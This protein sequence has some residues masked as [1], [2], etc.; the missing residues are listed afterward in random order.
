MMSLYVV[1]LH[2]IL[3]GLLRSILSPHSKREAPLDS[4][5]GPVVFSSEAR[6]C[7]SQFNPFTECN[8]NN[9]N[10]FDQVGSLLLFIF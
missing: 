2:F 5:L 1:F 9:P 8:F 10:K 4:P 7:T 6:D 3:Q